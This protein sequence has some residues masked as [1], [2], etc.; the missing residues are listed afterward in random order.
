[1][2]MEALIVHYCISIFAQPFIAAV[3]QFF[4]STS[5]NTFKIKME[6]LTT[7]FASYGKLT[8]LPGT[9]AFPRS[10]LSE[11]DAAVYFKTLTSSQLVH[12]TNI[13][14]TIN[15][16]APTKCFHRNIQYYQ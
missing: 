13:Y 7:S 1:M 10:L 14:N 9:R 6:M 4:W 3:A 15:C 2:E 11:D 5:E 8:S 12:S 16:I